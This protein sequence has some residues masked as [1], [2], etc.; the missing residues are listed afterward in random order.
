[1]SKPNQSATV[2]NTERVL[3]KLSGISLTQM[4]KGTLCNCRRCQ[5]DNSFGI[6]C[7]GMRGS[8]FN[9]EARV[10][11]LFLLSLG[12]NPVITSPHIVIH[13]VWKSTRLLHLSLTL[14]VLQ[15][16]DRKGHFWPV[17]GYF[18][19]CMFLVAALPGPAHGM[20]DSDHCL[21]SK[22]PQ[23]HWK[24]VFFLFFFKIK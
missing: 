21:G 18:R 19:E 20:A 12:K 6:W 16:E 14:Q 5:C 23:G 2:C 3:G 7:L 1:M 8:C 4:L 15:K 11:C 13:V 22:I 17:K 9:F 24:I 10:G